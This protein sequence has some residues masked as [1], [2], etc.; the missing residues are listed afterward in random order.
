MA[1]ALAPEPEQPL[2]Q[3]SCAHHHHH[4]QPQG[5]RSANPLPP[6]RG[7]TDSLKGNLVSQFEIARLNSFL[8][9][10]F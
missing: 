4:H 5:L 6:G 9:Q 3:G 2:P 10:N 1:L 7:A 8:L